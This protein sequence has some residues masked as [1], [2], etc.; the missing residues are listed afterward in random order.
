MGKKAKKQ[1][2]SA[3]EV[4]QAPAEGTSKPLDDR[5]AWRAEGK[6]WL[7]KAKE[8]IKAK[9][10]AIRAKEEALRR[11]EAKEKE[12]K[13]KTQDPEWQRK[14][15]KRREQQAKREAQRQEFW[16]RRRA[17]EEARWR[18]EAERSRREDEAFFKDMRARLEEAMRAAFGD[19]AGSGYSRSFVWPRPQAPQC[20]EVLG[21][22]STATA[23]ELKKRYR[24]LAKLFHPDRGGDEATFKK[25]NDAHKEAAKL[26]GLR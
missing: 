21:L 19:R 8:Q 26:L 23:V 9:E 24:E 11:R 18:E 1:R 10:D 7:R 20:W 13:A 2:E 15:A 3:P 17:E 16:A 4:E 6:E 14:Q 5:E 25:I 22:P 12:R